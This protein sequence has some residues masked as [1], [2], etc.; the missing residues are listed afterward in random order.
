M[1]CIQVGR[2]LQRFLDGEVD[3]LTARRILH[4]LEDCRRCGLE[5][6]AYTAIKASLARRRGDAPGDALVRL[7]LFGEQL[8]REG[9]PPEADAAGGA[10]GD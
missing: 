7:R 9:P 1:N 3:D 6:A 2:R 8:L 10:A 4:H 5:V